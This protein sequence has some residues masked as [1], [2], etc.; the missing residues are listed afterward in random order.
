MPNHALPPATGHCYKLHAHCVAYRSVTCK[1]QEC[2]YLCAKPSIPNMHVHVCAA[3]IEYE[4]KVQCFRST[5]VWKAVIV[6]GLGVNVDVK[7]NQ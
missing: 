4:R 5:G 3:M 1:P 7:K 2:L 6:K